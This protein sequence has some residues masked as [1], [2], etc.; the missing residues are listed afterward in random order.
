MS[1]ATVGNGPY[2]RPGELEACSENF[3]VQVNQDPDVVIVRNNTE[4]ISYAESQRFLS[5]EKSIGG[6]KYIINSME[7][8]PHTACKVSCFNQW[9]AS[10]INHP[11]FVE[12]S[13]RE[14]LISSELSYPYLIRLNNL[15]TGQGTYLIESDSDLD[16]Y[17]PVLMHEFE[18]RGGYNRKL[19]AIELIDTKRN[20]RYIS[21]RIAIAGNSVVSAY[22][23][24][25]EDWL[26]ITS[27]FKSEYKYLFIEENKRIQRI[28]SSNQ[29]EICRSISSLGLEHQGLD[30]ILDQS[31]KMYFIEVQPFYFCGDTGRTTPPFWNPYKPPELVRW[32]VDEKNDLYKEIPE[33]YDN[34]LDKFNHFKIA[35]KSLRE[36]YNVWSKSNT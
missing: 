13:S 25:S 21:Y 23:R 15:A 1:F 11:S 8:F 9:G 35:Y 27:R 36:S 12:F 14:E 24:I 7:S 26:A 4:G 28:V 22:A 2:W 3:G 19:F 17:Y 29:E 20:G 18:T 16:K 10:G 32:L 31:E 6:G 33:Y 30:L 34:W 5:E